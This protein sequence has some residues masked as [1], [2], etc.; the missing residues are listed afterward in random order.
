MRSRRI[1][2]RRESVVHPRSL[3]PGDIAIGFHVLLLARSSHRV[4]LSQWH[5][6]NDCVCMLH[7]VCSASSGAC[8]LK[9]EMKPAT[10]DELFRTTFTASRGG[11][12]SDGN[13]G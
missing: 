13:P 1:P 9:I 4:S 10:N 3:F 6:A 11:R 8:S 12:Y 7:V 5:G 2:A